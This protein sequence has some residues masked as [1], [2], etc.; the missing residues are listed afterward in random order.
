MA[1]DI[2]LKNT[3]NH[4][5][6]IES[7]G[8][9]IGVG[10]DAVCGYE[11][12]LSLGNSDELTQL[13][14]DGDIVV[15]NGFEDLNSENAL[16]YLSI[17]S[18]Y[19]NSIYTKAETDDIINNILINNINTLEE[20]LTNN[21]PTTADVDLKISQVSGSGIKGSVDY[22]EDLPADN[23]TGD[24]YIVRYSSGQGVDAVKFIPDGK[25]GLYLPNDVS[26][27]D[28]L[29][30]TGT[31]YGAPSNVD[32]KIINALE[33]NG[34]NQYVIFDSSD[35]FGIGTELSVGVWLY[36]QRTGNYGIIGKWSDRY[37]G[38][39]W[40]IDVHGNKLR[41]SLDTHCW[42]GTNFK[43]PSNL[44]TEQW[45]HVAFVYNGYEV[46]MYLNAMPVNSVQIQGRIDDNELDLLI[47][48][49][50][51]GVESIDANDNPDKLYQGLMD[52]VFIENR[53]MSQD[54]LERLIFTELQGYHDEGFYKYNG[55]SWDFLARNTGEN[56]V[57]SHADLLGLNS[58]DYQHLTVLEKDGLTGGLDTDLH[59]HDNMYYK[60]SEIDLNLSQKNHNHDSSYY[61][62]SEVDGL[63]NSITFSKI[64]SNDSSTNVT[65]AEIELLTNGGN[66]DGLHTHSSSGGTDIGGLDSAYD[67]YNQYAQGQ[68]RIVNVD[69]GPIQLSAS[70]G[71]AP[72]RLTEINYKPNQWLGGGEICYQDGELFIYQA[73]RNKWLSVAMSHETFGRAGNG[74]DGWMRQ[75]DVQ[76][77]S[78][79]GGLVY[80]WPATIVAASCSAK[81]Q[82]NGY[83]IIAKN[84][85]SIIDL[86]WDENKQIFWNNLN[87]DIDA[88]DRIAIWQSG[89]YERPNYP[90]YTVFVRR[91]LTN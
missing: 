80:P 21:Y 5:I 81:N 35:D 55:S 7:F 12:I 25:T 57:Q 83:F 2:I 89:N 32:G 14:V 48:K 50:M 87:L 91:R 46:I 64:A 26:W 62:K 28:N 4:L 39:G 59:K 15:N 24:I 10:D 34:S 22:F 60:K 6:N 49:Y 77:G 63:I 68:G 18:D 73:E 42:C 11:D 31:A 3:T 82:P 29:G 56:A 69:G 45:V 36:P 65:G 72:L 20:N 53:V 76:N 37:D 85:S 19:L 13:I 70:S 71:F 54:E 33:F 1:K 74:R 66:A 78:S 41:V 9:L 61:K 58:G 52:E 84:G 86:Y 16:K 67:A 17:G 44:P 38:S 8:L 40:K 51:T 90:N 27:E 30:H 47:G 43:S 79:Y 88:G 23:S 75:G